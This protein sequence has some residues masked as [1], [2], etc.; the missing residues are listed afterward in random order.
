[1]SSTRTALY[2]HGHS[3]LASRQAMLFAFFL[4]FGFM[5]AELVGGVLANS[6]ALIADAGHMVSDAAALGLGLAAMWMASHPHTER[7]TFGFHRA[8]ILAALANGALLLAIAFVVSWHALAR[9]REPQPVASG[10]MLVIALVGL[11][12]NLAAIQVLGRHRHANLNVRGAFLHVLGDALGSAGVIVAALVIR[13]TGFTPI[14][15]IVSLFI[16]ALIVFS[17]WRLVRETVSVLLESSPRHVDSEALRRDLVAIPG[18]VD[19]HDLHIWT[20]TSGFVSLS[21]HAEVFS[22]DIADDVLRAATSL[23]R[24]R[25]GIRHVTIQPETSRVH[26]ELEHCCLDDHEPRPSLRRF[27]SPS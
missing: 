23:L 16:A 10:P 15:A 5:I 11:V 27:L 8:E 25:Y 2:S 24:E 9:L 26:E 7:R 4:T 3:R 22:A 18:V 6:L 13:W 19:V 1:M 14:D 20:V 17:G 21:C 12:V